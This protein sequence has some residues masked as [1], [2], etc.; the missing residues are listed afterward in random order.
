MKLKPDGR[1][2]TIAEEQ[3]WRS[4]WDGGII[5]LLC[6]EKKLAEDKAW[7]IS[8]GERFNED[9]GVPANYARPGIGVADREY[10][11]GC[12]RCQAKPPLE[13]DWRTQCEDQAT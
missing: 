7:H 1:A 12:C 11:T 9:W 4:F 2:L 13:L 6:I 3:G 10:D 8:R 5:C